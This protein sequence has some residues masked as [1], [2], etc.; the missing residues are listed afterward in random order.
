MKVGYFR[1]D[2]DLVYHD[3]IEGDLFTQS[4]RTV[5]LLRSKYLKAVIS[6]QGLQRVETLPVARGSAA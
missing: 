1:S 3:Q 6:Y 2:T 5:E 4:Q